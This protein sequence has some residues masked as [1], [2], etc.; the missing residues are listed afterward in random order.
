MSQIL[1]EWIE[2]IRSAGQ[3]EIESHEISLLKADRKK[4]IK[5]ILLLEIRP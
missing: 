5:L 2:V 1:K 4:G 3:E